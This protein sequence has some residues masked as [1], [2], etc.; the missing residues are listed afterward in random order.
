MGFKSINILFAVVI[1]ICL[2]DFTNSE[3]K[4]EVG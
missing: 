1:I 2:N 4:C 3:Q